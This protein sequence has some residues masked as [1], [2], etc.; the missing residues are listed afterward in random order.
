MVSDVAH[1][2]CEACCELINRNVDGDLQKE[3]VILLYNHVSQ[4][5]DCR[6][7][8]DEMAMLEADLCLLSASVEV[9]CLQPDFNRRLMAC[10]AAQPHPVAVAAWVRVRQFVSHWWHKAFPDVQ[11]API[12]AGVALGMLAV[13]LL[14]PTFI[15]QNSNPTE[16]LIIQEIPLKSAQDSVHWNY[17]KTVQPGE[18]MKYLIK[19]DNNDYVHFKMASTGTASLQLQLQ[20]LGGKTPLPYQVKLPGIRYASVKT[21]RNNDA[22]LISNMGNHPVRIDAY[23]PAPQSVQVNFVSNH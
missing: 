5:S 13:F 12:V 7:F 6:E 3:E 20:A 17:R 11:T 22:V 18:S 4:C 23:S 8:M 15:Q 9:H 2:G 21:P 10:I 16:R 1:V 14:A 19:Q